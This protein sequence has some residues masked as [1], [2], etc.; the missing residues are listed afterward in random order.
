MKT[1]KEL[2]DIFRL[3]QSNI[4]KE[5]TFNIGKTK[6]LELR[7]EIQEIYKYIF[8]T[9][10]KED[11]SKMPLKNDKTIAYYLYHLTRIEDITSNTLISEKEQIFFKNG[12]NKSINSP[13]ITT[14]NEIERDK[15]IEFS[16]MLDIDELEK[17]TE[18]VLE[19][20]NNIINKMTYSESKLKISQERKEELLKLNT[21]STDENAFWLVDYW[22]KK[23]QAGLLLMPFSR[24][25]MLHLNGC[26][27]IIKK[28]K[29]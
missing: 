16:S 10:S 18:D 22:C 4:K 13:I 3:F 8:S 9:C 27:R 29:K 14:G 5:S 1:N 25:Q 12:F 11:F 23:T 24:H 19:N 6:L 2:A 21:V 17:Y 7:G 28:I 15:L 20:T 26:K